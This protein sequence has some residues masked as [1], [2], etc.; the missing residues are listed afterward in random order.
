LCVHSYMDTY[1]Q[2]EI[3]CVH[4]YMDTYEESEKLVYTKFR[5]EHISER[6]ATTVT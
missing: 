4:S 5:H 6:N 3:L 2:A 1:G